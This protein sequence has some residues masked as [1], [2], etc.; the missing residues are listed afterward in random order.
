MLPFLISL[1]VSKSEIP[2]Q[3]LLL[4]ETFLP[5]LLIV[6]S[7][8]PECLSWN[9]TYNGFLF[10]LFSFFPY[11][12]EDY[13]LGYCRMKVLFSVLLTQV[14]CYRC[15]ERIYESIDNVCQKGQVFWRL[16]YFCANTS[17]SLVTIWVSHRLLQ[18]TRHW[19]CR[20][21][22]FLEPLDQILLVNW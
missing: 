18:N 3:T 13:L 7:I 14:S 4:Q 9:G 1:K 19:M 2:T 5:S 17:G 15:R 21:L 11:P 22:G 16:G 6:I 8:S 10:F 12:R 20:K